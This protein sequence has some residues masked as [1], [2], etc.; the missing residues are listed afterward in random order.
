VGAFLGLA[1]R[2]EHQHARA[3]ADIETYSQSSSGGVLSPPSHDTHHTWGDGS[4]DGLSAGPTLEWHRPWGLA[5]QS[6]MSTQ[7]LFQLDDSDGA[8][9][10]HGMLASSFARAVHIV[11][12]R[13]LVQAGAGHQRW[14]HLGGVSSPLGTDEGWLIQYGADL[15]YYLEDRAQL[16]LSASEFQARNDDFVI[17]STVRPFTRES[18]ISLV[19]SY[20]LLGRVDAPGVMPPIRL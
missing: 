8:G 12:D 9:S 5:T 18:R 20:H 15:I 3:W 7:V 16:R 1:V 6:Q 11:A 13:W 14:T 19:F 4:R 10:D 17:G 2:G